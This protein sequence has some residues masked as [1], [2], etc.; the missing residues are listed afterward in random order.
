MRWPAPSTPPPVRPAARRR[1]RLRRRR[2]GRAPLHPCAAGRTRTSSHQRC[3]TRSAP[4]RPRRSTRRQGWRTP[5]RQAPRPFRRGYRR[6][7]SPPPAARPRTPPPPI[8]SHPPV[9]RPGTPPRAGS[10]ASRHR[11][12]AANRRPARPRP[13]RRSRPH[14]AGPRDP[15][16]RRTPTPPAH[17]SSSTRLP[18]PTGRYDEAA[19]PDDVAENL[20]VRESGGVRVAA[21]DAASIGR[22]RGR[23]ARGRCPAPSPSPHCRKQLATPIRRCEPRESHGAAFRG[24]RRCRLAGG[25][26]HGSWSSEPSHSLGGARVSQRIPL[27]DESPSRSGGY[28]VGA[29]DEAGVQGVTTTLPTALR[30]IRRRSASPAPS[31]GYRPDTCGRRSPD[32]TRLISSSPI[33]VLIAGSRAD[34]AP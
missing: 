17:Q 20:V 12:G 31:R 19:R 11:P 15:A 7:S 18:S 24:S 34:I 32:A 1:C 29:R 13:R 27:L 26:R 10:T 21:N 28:R 30:S 25:R 6:P 33:A 9:P 23:R 22:R 14:P 3:R 4:R 8:R 16:H 5:T 2:P